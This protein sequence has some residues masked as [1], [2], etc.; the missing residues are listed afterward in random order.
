MGVQCAWFFSSCCFADDRPQEGRLSR[1]GGR[2]VKE[3]SI[4]DV[5]ARLG[6]FFRQQQDGRE[7]GCCDY[8]SGYKSDAFARILG[9]ARCGSMTT[10]LIPP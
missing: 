6:R 5:D 4:K 8:V 1:A 9:A 7:A 3:K 10:P 2:G